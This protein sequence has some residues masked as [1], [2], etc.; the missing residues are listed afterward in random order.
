MQ[1]DQG[2]YPSGRAVQAA[3]KSAALK[4]ERAKSV[5]V[6]DLIR[7]ATFDRFLCRIFSDQS[8]KFALKGGTGMLARLSTSRATTDIDLSAQESE[9][10]TAVAELRQLASVDLDDHF[11]FEFTNTIDQLEG[12]NQPYTA[13]CRL[14]F[15]VYVGVTKQSTLSIDLAAGYKP[16]GMLETVSPANRL[17]L[18]RLRTCDYVL[19]PLADQVADKL[20]ATQ[21]KYGESKSP[22]S[23]VKDLIDLLL[24]SLTESM[25]A[26]QLS[27]AVATESKR[28]SLDPITAFLI[29]SDWSIRYLV[30]A[31]RL[32]L[33]DRFPDAASAEERVQAM[34]NPILDGSLADGR[35]EPSAGVW[36]N[37]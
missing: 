31:R 19:Y 24:I 12:E 33:V 25:D 8:T 14:T 17:P 21:A 18:T 32:G 26:R 29:P 7:Q 15:D 16:T 20:C 34:L 23:R 5:G 37:T 27:I 13:G 35:W 3:I 28:R 11:R 30:L 36:R 4:D 10:D 9:L 2:A 1:A 6:G 22:S